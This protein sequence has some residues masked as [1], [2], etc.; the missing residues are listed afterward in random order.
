MRE[1]LLLE[2]QEYRMW[3]AY[4]FRNYPGDHS[5]EVLFFLDNF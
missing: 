5:Y 1:V 3:A 2:L 4:I